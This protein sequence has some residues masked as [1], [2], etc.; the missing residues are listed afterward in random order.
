MS[1]SD[2]SE[3]W[4]ADIT[5]SVC[6]S[7]FLPYFRSVGRFK[8]YLGLIYLLSHSPPG[9]EMDKGIN[10]LANVGTLYLLHISFNGDL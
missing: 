7:P 2:L 10:N 5:E 4:N 3:N 8:R 1:N 6:S 9:D